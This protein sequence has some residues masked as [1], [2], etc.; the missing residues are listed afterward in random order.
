[1]IS[2]GS[3]NDSVAFI[4]ITFGDND[5]LAAHLANMIDA[6]LLILLTD[7]DGLYD[8]DPKRIEKASILRSVERIDDDLIRSSRGKGSVFSSGG[9][10]SKLKAARI[11]TRSGIG[12]IIA[13]GRKA[14][15]A[16]LMEGG[17][18]GT[19]FTPGRKKIR[20]KKKWIAFNPKIDGK[21]V[22]DTGGQ[23]AI[24][25]SR[26]SLLPAGVIDV[27]G[28]FGMGGNVSIV[29]E[30]RH[31]VARGLTNFSSED[32][33]KI[34]GLQTGSIPQVLGNESYFEEVVHRDNMVITSQ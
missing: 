22:I 30:A 4:E 27:I 32:L 1:M 6:D 24:I 8:R 13:N 7:I 21:I 34:K 12:V 11:A 19:Y 25:E 17:E 16:R 20:G 10:E 28:D 26:K 14:S 29:N 33:A 31:E 18:I 2:P 5:I 3:K 15:L 23:R 9:M